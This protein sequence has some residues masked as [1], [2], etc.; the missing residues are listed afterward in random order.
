MVPRL[1]CSIPASA[2]IT[3]PVI[4]LEGAQARPEVVGK[5]VTPRSPLA[6]PWRSGPA[7]PFDEHLPE[8]EP[9]VVVARHPG[10]DRFGER[11]SRIVPRV[12]APS[13]P[14][15]SWR[16]AFGSASTAR[17]GPRPSAERIDQ[18]RGRGGFARAALARERDPEGGIRSPPARLGRPRPLPAGS[19]PASSSFANLIPQSA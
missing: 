4:P 10:G 8:S 9:D 1:M 16:F 6:G 7:R 11:S 3:R 2:S 14:R 5:A 19:G 12:S 18:K 13:S 17:T 15:A